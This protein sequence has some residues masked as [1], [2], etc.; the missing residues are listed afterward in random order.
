MPG[1]GI[2]INTRNQSAKMIILTIQNVVP[3]A[4]LERSKIDVWVNSQVPTGCGLKSSSATSTAVA[5][6]CSTIFNPDIGERKMLLAGID[7][8]IR[9][10]VSMSGAYDDACACYYG[11]INMTHNP[12]MTLLNRVKTSPDLRVV[13]FVP[14][15]RNRKNIRDLK[16][17]DHVLGTAWR[18]AMDGRYWDAMVMNGIAMSAVLGPDP[19]LLNSLMSTGALASSLSGN[20]PAVATVVREGEVRDVEK[21]LQPL[22]GHIIVTA[23]NNTRAYSHEL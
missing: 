19:Y 5:M 8:S 15:D 14:D 1:R 12:R 10:G 9:S 21:V 13:I 18:L 6:A 16:K 11:G 2:T 4:E 20:G 23:V 3:A 7:A 22:S 17:M